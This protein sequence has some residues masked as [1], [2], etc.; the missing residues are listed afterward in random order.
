MQGVCLTHCGLGMPYGWHRF[1]I[2]SGNG[3][4]PDGT[5]PLPK[6]MLTNHQLGQV[7]ITCGQIHKSHQWIRMSLNSLQKYIQTPRDQW[8]NDFFILFWLCGMCMVRYANNRPC[9]V[10]VQDVHKQVT[11]EIHHRSSTKKI[12]RV[13][14]NLETCLRTPFV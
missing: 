7:K 4:L 1:N 12:L 11:I 14:L 9:K 5:K 13:K 3:L 6:P 8:V 2:G 10:F